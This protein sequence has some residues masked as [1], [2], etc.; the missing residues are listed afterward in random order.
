MKAWL[1]DAVAATGCSEIHGMSIGTRSTRRP[2]WMVSAGAPFTN[3][4]ISTT[5]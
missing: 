1:A 2:S 4:L 3:W 5:S